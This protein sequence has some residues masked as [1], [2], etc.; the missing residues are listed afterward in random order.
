MP[1]VRDPGTTECSHIDFLLQC[2]HPFQSFKATQTDKP[3]FS[4][5]AS[6]SALQL[7]ARHRIVHSGPAVSI[8]DSA[9]AYLVNPNIWPHQQIF[10]PCTIL[11]F[12]S[13]SIL[14][15]NPLSAKSKHADPRLYHAISLA[16]SQNAIPYSHHKINSP[17]VQTS[18][19][20]K[21]KKAS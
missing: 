15:K 20:H 14:P 13:P 17:H 19:S 12:P 9:Q 4:P 11:T 6:P 2:Q 16:I 8:Q 7:A 3:S 21:E 18:K 1:E 10:R 5:S